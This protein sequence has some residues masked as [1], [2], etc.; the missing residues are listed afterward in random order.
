MTAPHERR[1]PGGGVPF[2]LTPHVEPIVS[3]AID[4][5]PPPP[6]RLSPPIA[7]PPKEPQEPQAPQADRSR[8]LRTPRSPAPSSCAHG[9]SA[10][11]KPPFSSLPHAKVVTPL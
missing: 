7:E 9:R 5:P 4:T 2:P 3:A 6:H 11:R 10:P 1:R 8:L